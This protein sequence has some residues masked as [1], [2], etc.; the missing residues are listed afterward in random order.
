[1]SIFASA[2]TPISV[3]SAK[4]NIAS[5]EKFI[6][7]I[8]RLRARIVSFLSLNYQM[9]HVSLNLIFFILIVKIL[10][11]WERFRLYVNAM[12]LRL[13][14]HCLSQKKELRRLFV[15]LRSLRKTF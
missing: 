3:S 13:Y 10:M 12:V 9:L 7:F 8:G 15:T 2:F 1:M 6:L 5:A 4:E 11:N 14:L